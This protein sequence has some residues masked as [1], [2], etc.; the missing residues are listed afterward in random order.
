MNGSEMCIS[1]PGK[2]YIYPS[3]TVLAPRIPVTPAPVPMDAAEG[4]N[5]SCGRWYRVELGDYC[6]MIVIKFGTSLED[7]RFLNPVINENCTNLYAEESYCVL[8]VGDS[9]LTLDITLVTSY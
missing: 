9:E 4:T 5:I 1:A 7:F 2:Q 8:A 3:P 6:N